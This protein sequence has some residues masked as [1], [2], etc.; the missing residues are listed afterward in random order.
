MAEDLEFGLGE[1]GELEEELENNSSEEEE[2]E[3]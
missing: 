1:E 2:E 3:M